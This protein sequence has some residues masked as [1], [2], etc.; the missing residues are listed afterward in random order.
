MEK[1]V[2]C[3]NCGAKLPDDGGRFCPKCGKPIEGKGAEENVEGAK[4]FPFDAI[5]VI[6][7]I[8]VAVWIGCFAGGGIEFFS[9]Y[10]GRMAGNNDNHFAM[11]LVELL[12]AGVFID[13]GIVLSCLFSYLGACFVRASWSST[14]SINKYL[15]Y[16]ATVP[17]HYFLNWGAVAYGLAS[18]LGAVPNP[19]ELYLG[20]QY[21]NFL[22][23]AFAAGF[24]VAAPVYLVFGVVY[25]AAEACST[26]RSQ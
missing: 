10:V 12:V 1:V 6:S 13:I 22:T 23:A 8:L 11:F 24:F 9:D 16:L 4:A 3:V 18:Y 17:F 2:Y 20:I 26:L 25:L 7:G 21:D 14:A 19:C 15:D 5:T